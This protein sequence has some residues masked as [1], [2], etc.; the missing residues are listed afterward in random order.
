ETRDPDATLRG[1]LYPHGLRFSPDGGL[2]FAADAGA[3]FVH[4][5]RNDGAAWRGDLYPVASLRVIDDA[6]YNR[7]RAN[8]QE[9]GPKGLDLS[10][11]GSVLVVTCEEVPFVCLDLR[12]LGLPAAPTGRT[13]PPD[14]GALL[15]M[16]EA[17]HRRIA[18]M[19]D[20]DIERR[21]LR[22]KLHRAAEK[23]L[24]VLRRAFGAARHD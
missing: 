6:S 12:G 15:A 22:A 14:D 10:P 18:S 2:L 4:V 16:A 5:Y 11:D 1:I 19:P 13:G 8:P 23:A 3:P 20:P 9:G 17:R 7:G 21:P 24:R